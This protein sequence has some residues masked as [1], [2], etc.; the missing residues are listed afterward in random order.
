MTGARNPTAPG[1]AFDDQGLE[2]IRLALEGVI[3]PG[4]QVAA[5]VSE[6]REMHEAAGMAPADAR[7]IAYRQGYIAELLSQG[8]EDRREIARRVGCSERTVRGDVEALRRLVAP[9]TR[10]AQGQEAA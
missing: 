2:R 1:V 5:W 6:L 10:F 3:D 8:V 9:R 7:R 4:S